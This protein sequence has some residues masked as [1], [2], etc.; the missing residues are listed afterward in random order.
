[1]AVGGAVAVGGDPVGADQDVAPAGVVEVHPLHGEQQGVVG[2]G[3]GEREVRMLALEQL[4]HRIDDRG[5]A[6]RPGDR[7]AVELVDRP[8]VLAVEHLVEAGRIALGGE[9][10]QGRVVDVQPGPEAHRE[11][12]GARHAAVGDRGQRRPAGQHAVGEQAQ[13]A[14]LAGH[15]GSRRLDQHGGP[16]IG[17]RVGE[18]CAAQ[19]P[20]AATP[21]RR[22]CSG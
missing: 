16:D 20:R 9:L 17:Q 6:D 18:R 15:P 1:M 5:E 14:A 21:E 7:V 3:D 12:D 11:H 8:G 2:G 4:Q 22:S 19:R 13:V 10:S